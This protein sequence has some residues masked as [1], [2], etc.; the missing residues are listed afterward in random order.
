[1]KSNSWGFGIPKVTGN[2]HRGC[3]AAD[4]L[5]TSPPFRAHFGYVA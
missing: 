4:W 3:W 2:V 5:A 1:M